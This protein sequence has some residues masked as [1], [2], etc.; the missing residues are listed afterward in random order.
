MIKL[1]F[2]KAIFA[3]LSMKCAEISG[4]GM[5]LDASYLASI[6]YTD[7]SQG[8]SILD[9][10]T[11]IDLN[12]FKGYTRLQAIYIY[13]DALQNLDMEVFEN[14]IS[15]QSLYLYGS[16]L[17]QLT[18]AKKLTF[19]NLLVLEI[20]KSKIKFDQNMIN[21]FPNLTLA[22]LQFSGIYLFYNYYSG[23][24]NILN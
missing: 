5:I 21:G 2:F 7:Q 6:G 9:N 23:I 17:T 16:H 14:S 22:V 4:A 15:L 13:S 10:I 8:I 3:L 18:N 24:K 19:Y 1:I 12:A 20:P 11:S